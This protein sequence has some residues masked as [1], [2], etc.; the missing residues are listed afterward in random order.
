MSGISPF[1]YV[2]W[3]PLHD[4]VDDGGAFHIDQKASLKVMKKEQKAGLVNGPTVFNMMN[5]HKPARMK[6]GQVL[7]FNPFVI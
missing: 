1:T 5:K 2:L 3:A 7:F 6:F 4:I